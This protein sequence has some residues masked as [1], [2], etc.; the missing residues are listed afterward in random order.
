MNPS[1]KAEELLN[2][3]E[4]HIETQKELLEQENK[5]LLAN[6]KV[7]TRESIALDS[8]KSKKTTLR[9]LGERLGRFGSR[10]WDVCKSVPRWLRGRIKRRRK[11]KK[12][13]LNDIDMS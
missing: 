7:R 6:S 11:R 3:L 9:A 12:T 8:G 1:K 10:S 5:R 2:A 13:S 4:E